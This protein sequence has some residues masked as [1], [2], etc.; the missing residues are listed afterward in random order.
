MTR[1]GGNVVCFQN[2]RQRRG[3]SNHGGECRLK[4]CWLHHVGPEEPDAMCGCSKVCCVYQ[5]WSSNKCLDQVAG[6]GHCCCALLARVGVLQDVDQRRSL[7]QLEK[8][9]DPH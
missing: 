3:W 1:R 9:D 8:V 7:L 5:D 6:L 2:C 4:L